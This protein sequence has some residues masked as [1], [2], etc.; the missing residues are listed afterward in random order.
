[1]KLNYYT[2]SRDVI[3]IYITILSKNLNEC[4]GLSCYFLSTVIEH[5]YSLDFYL[6]LMSPANTF[7]HPLLQKH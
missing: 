6:I 2:F 4:R 5:R 3:Q 7:L 1:M